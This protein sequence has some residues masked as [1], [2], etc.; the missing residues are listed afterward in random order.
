[1]KNYNKKNKLKK[2]NEFLNQEIKKPQKMRFLHL[3]NKKSSLIHQS[4]NRLNRSKI[5][6]SL[7][8]EINNY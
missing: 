8:K 7:K 3:I 4:K 1:M 5:K 6:I 2:I